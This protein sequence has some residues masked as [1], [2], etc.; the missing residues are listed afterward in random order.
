MFYE[1]LI[2]P[3][4]GGAKPLALSGTVLTSRKHTCMHMTA[5]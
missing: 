4:S 3:A 5:N 2:T 1:L